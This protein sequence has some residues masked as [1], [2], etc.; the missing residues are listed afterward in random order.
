MVEPLAVSPRI[1]VVSRRVFVSALSAVIGGLIPRA[2]LGFGEHQRVSAVHQNTDHWHLHVAINKVHPTTLRNVTPI[3]DHYRLQAVQ[4]VMDK[5]TWD[6]N[7]F[8]ETDSLVN[9]RYLAYLEAT[10]PQLQKAIGPATNLPPVLDSASELYLIGQFSQQSGLPIYYLHPSFGYFFERYYG[11]PRGLAYQLLP[12]AKEQLDAPALTE[13]EINACL[14]EWKN[15]RADFIDSLPKEIKAAPSSDSA[16]IGW[17]CSRSANVWG[18]ELQAAN[19][20]K[21]AGDAFDLACKLNSHNQ[22]APTV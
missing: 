9:E 7:I 10:Y 6:K 18:V 3:R 19:R 15:A 8:I 21:E 4:G 22:M 17:L 5:A 12:Y 13:G 16:S 2:A 1:R 11:R 14:A 20:L